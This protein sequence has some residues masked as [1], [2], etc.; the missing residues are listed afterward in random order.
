MPF[1][2]RNS[3]RKRTPEDV[4]CELWVDELLLLV[5]ELFEELVDPLLELEVEVIDLDVLVLLLRIMTHSPFT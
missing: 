2:V 5:L 1:A 3:V 4:E